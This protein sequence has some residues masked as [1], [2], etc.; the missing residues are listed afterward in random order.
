MKG[1]TSFSRRWFLVG[2]SW[3]MLFHPFPN[4]RNQV[5]GETGVSQ[6]AESS[7]I[8]VG[9]VAFLL[10]LLVLFTSIIDLF[11]NRLLFRAGPEVLAHMDFPGVSSIAVAGRISFTFEQLALYVILASAALVLLRENR[12]FPRWLGLLLIP[13]LAT[14]ALLYLPL[15]LDLA[16]ALSTILVLV[17]AMEVFGLIIFRAKSGHAPGRQRIVQGAFLLLLGLSFFFPL[18]YRVYL[19]L[20]TLNFASLPFGIGIYSAGIYSILA[21]SVA[22]FVYALTTPSSRF[23]I[24]PRN[25]VMAVILPTI[26]V[27]PILY[28]LME[29]FFMVQIF[30]LVIAMST[31]I[32]LSFQFVRATVF[33]WWFLLTAVVILLLKGRGS[34]NRFLLQQGVGLI[35]ILSTTFL[36]NYPNYILLGTAGV[37]LLTYPLQSR[38]QTHDQRDPE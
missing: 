11:V 20:G 25:F 23:R 38:E 7:R 32:A 28:G 1:K 27:A 18:S 34:D 3:V 12:A 16:W 30:S 6:Q 9:R 13:Q 10:S 22:A 8:S 14:A 26:V 17:T 2:R 31:D 33:F 36:F 24:T 21:A 35:L 29:S 15:S 5:G 37:L 19:L 4:G